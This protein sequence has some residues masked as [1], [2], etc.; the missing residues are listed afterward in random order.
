MPALRHESVDI[1]GHGEGQR[2][3]DAYG[4]PL[5][6]EIAIDPRIRVGGD[7]GKPMASLG[8]DALR[9]RAAFMPWRG[10][11]VS[12]LLRLALRAVGRVFEI[13]LR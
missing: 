3:A 2:V 6:G 11:W 1:F 4:V 12:G 13:T 10:R 9:A 8:E 7:T 5:L